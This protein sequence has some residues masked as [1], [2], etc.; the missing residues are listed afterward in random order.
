[1]NTGYGRLLAL[2]LVG[3]LALRVLALVLA[4][5]DL[6]F[7]EAQYWSWSR[8]PAFG[9]FSKPPMIAWVIA[10]T[11]SLCGHG[12][13][14]VRLG[15][16]VLHTV[17]ALFL[18]LA[19]RALYDERTGFWAALV[20]ATMPG[21]SF[22]S[23]LI[24]TDVPLLA[25]WSAALFAWVKLLQT[26][27]WVWAFALGVALG[28]GLLSKY[29]MAYF[30]LCAGLYLI[31]EREARWLVRDARG[32]V[33]LVV[34]AL[35]IL[36][37]ILWNLDHGSVTFTHT[38][39]NAKWGGPLFHADQALAFFAA[40]F[41]VFGPILMGVLVWIAA[42]ALR[43]SPTG[44]DRMLLAFSVPVI[45]LILTQA[46]LSRAHANWA[47]VA[48]PAAAILVTATLLRL[49][50]ARLFRIS[51][52]LHLVV[53]AAITASHLVAPHFALPGK[54][55]PYGRTL[56]WR[57]FAA[58]VRSE[59]TARPYATLLSDDRWYTA[60]LLYYLR[61]STVPIKAWRPSPAPRDHYEL[62][63]PFGKGVGEPV[64]L[65][66]PHA[67]AEY[68][69]GHFAAAEPLGAKRVPAGPKGHRTVH[70]YALTGFKGP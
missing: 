8:E 11:T 65:V 63:R 4:D 38:A 35:M 26:R 45:L 10:A 5:T 46:F 64:L 24:S 52:V 59:L 68:I 47:A 22:S 37:N 50:A 20:F 57:D 44:P 23:G 13:A 69:T 27:A 56:G 30:Y 41:A 9:Y 58:A 6:I 25:C 51:L 70:F 3:L 48:Y 29:A 33:L 32:L 16:P 12:E 67:A 36:P 31:A 7:D 39:A 28:F 14:C 66:T 49:D 61:D 43:Q 15:A 2:A 55:D 18:Y 53:L 1:M 17:S 40:Q 21:I 60:E 34:P 19:G 54:L 62:T 42:R